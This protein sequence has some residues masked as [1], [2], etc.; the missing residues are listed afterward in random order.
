MTVNLVLPLV[1]SLALMQVA[2]EGLIEELDASTA[3]TGYFKLVRTPVEVLG[4]ADAYRLNP[5]LLDSEQVQWR[6]YVPRNYDPQLPP[7]VL[8][9]IS[10][11]DWGGIPEEWRPVMEKKNL[12]WISASGAGSSAPVEQRMVKA[13]IA[14]RA[15]D[16]DY[17]IDESRVYIAGFAD[18]GQV[19]NLVQSAEP[20]VFKG[21]IY[22]CGALFW[23]D[24]KPSRFDTMRVN[25]H[26]FIRGCFDPKERDVRRVHEQYLDAGVE[27][28]KLI[29][30]QT[31]RRRLPQ[32]SYLESAIDY[33]DGVV[34]G[35]E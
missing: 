16:H 2:E 6:V 35:A 31:R 24:R 15:V 4:E 13:I 23:G 9:F 5:V 33:L 12:I 32:P 21:G 20:G 26:A 7:G 14:P 27:N 11:I 34:A 28:S 29:S 25:R 22:M 10:S 1:L 17:R 3:R 19:A 18:G 8:V 30:V